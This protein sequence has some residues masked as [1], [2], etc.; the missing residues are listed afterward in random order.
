MASGPLSG[1]RV[2]EMT[3][4]DARLRRQDVDRSRS[5]GRPPRPG[6]R[7]DRRWPTRPS[8]ARG[9][10]LDWWFDGGKDVVVDRPGERRRPERL[11]PARRARRSGDRNRAARAAR[12][13]GLRSR[14]RSV[15]VNPR[16]VQ[17]SLTPFGRTGPRAHWQTSDLVAGA[18]GGVLSVSGTPD[19]AVSAVGTPEPELRRVHGGHLRARRRVGRPRVRGRTA[20]R[21][22]AARDDHLV[23]REPLLPVV[24][25][26]PPAAPASGR[27]ARGR[28]TGSARTSWPTP[29]T[30][31]CNISTAPKPGAAL[32]VDG[33]GGRPGGR[34]ARRAADRGGA[35]P[36]APRDGRPIKRF[37]LTKD[38]GELFAE[39]QRRHIAFGE[40]QTVAQVAANPQYEFRG[41]FRP[42]EGFADVRMPGPFARFHRHAAS[43]RSS[44]RRRQPSSIEDAARRVGRPR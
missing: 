42:V 25:L 30:G 43:R 3:G 40:V 29:S 8:P 9:G 17:V 22:V 32:R 26:R 16:L 35:R 41:S 28:C 2:I 21:P 11:S 6:L 19:R 36:D 15:E 7:V 5:R 1:L 12:R 4:D 20:R 38:S 27:C 13:A 24:V 37:A 31:A 33:R 10:L 44:P 23:A 39:A 34:R 14:R 18:L